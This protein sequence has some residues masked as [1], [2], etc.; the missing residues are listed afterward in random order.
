MSRR[1]FWGPILKTSVAKDDVVTN[2]SFSQ[3]IVERDFRMLQEGQEMNPVFQK[4]LG[5]SFEMFV[6]VIPARPEEEALFQEPDSPLVDGS[7][8]GV[9]G[10]FKT[11]GVS[12]NPFQDFMVFQKHLGGIFESKLAHLPQEMDETLLFLPREPVVSRVEVRDQNAGVIFG[13]NRFWDFSSPA[14]SDLVVSQPFIDT[15]PQP[16]IR[17]RDFPASLI[18]M[19]MRACSDSLKDLSLFHLK[20]LT[21]ALKG[22]GQ[23]A[24][25][26]L[27]M[28]KTFKEFLYFIERKA[29]VIFQ[30]HSL[31]Q[32]V[33]T[34][35]AVRYFFRSI[36]S[37]HKLSAMAAIA[38]LFLKA[39][40]LRLR[41][42][43]VLLNMI[44]NLLDRA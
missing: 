15:G 17:A 37:R 38:A 16:M 7:L 6:S 2:H 35:I 39:S 22:L 43:N 26:D 5:Q 30:D 41:R 24:F 10:F 13:K 4:T 27:E 21:D 40:H 14:L 42:N 12:K 34:K 31:N 3:I 9:P 36:R 20:P 1:S 28:T 33:G 23:S 25:R 44:E 32:N 18:H 11:Q 29:M 19:K 8:K